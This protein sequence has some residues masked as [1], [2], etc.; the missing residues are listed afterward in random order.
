[1]NVAEVGVF[2][3]LPQGLSHNVPDMTHMALRL[4]HNPALPSCCSISLPKW[5]W[6]K[7]ATKQ[8]F[9]SKPTKRPRDLAAAVRNNPPDTAPG[10]D[11]P[12]KNTT[13]GGDNPLNATPGGSGEA[14]SASRFT[15][16][17]ASSDPPPSLSRS[18]WRGSANAATSNPL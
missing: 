16:E 8:H 13:P 1:L 2:K 5:Y 17:G 15:A 11:N 7:S 14:K 3:S 4:P 10:G 18:S 9:R 12:P 6:S